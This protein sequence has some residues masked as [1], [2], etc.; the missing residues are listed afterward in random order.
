MRR[1]LYRFSVADNKCNTF[2]SS[3]K[4]PHI[5]VRFQLKLDYLEIFSFKSP[6]K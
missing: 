3:C 2:M 5:S 6:I 4:V 1:I